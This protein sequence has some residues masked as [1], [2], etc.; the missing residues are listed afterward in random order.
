MELLRRDVSE[1]LHSQLS[2]QNFGSCAT[3]SKNGRRKG[4]EMP[5]QV[6][7]VA[8]NVDFRANFN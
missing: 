7:V 4:R 8:G 1:A 2:A 3:A 5:V 6:L